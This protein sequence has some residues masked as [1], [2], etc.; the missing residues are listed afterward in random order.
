MTRMIKIIV[1]FMLFMS[2]SGMVHAETAKDAWTSLVGKQYSKCPEF[3]FVPNNPALP[4]VL[5]YGD[6]ISMGYTLQVRNK[7]KNKANVYRLHCNGG[8]TARVIRAVETMQEQMADL[9]AISA[10]MIAA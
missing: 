1:A 7:L 6:S 4:N 3:A 8:D 10:L 2:I 9:F 5:I